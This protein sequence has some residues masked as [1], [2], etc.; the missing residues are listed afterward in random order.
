VKVCGAFLGIFFLASLLE[1]NVLSISLMGIGVM[2]VGAIVIL[3]GLRGEGIASLL[4][5][6]SFTRR[7]VGMVAAARDACRQLGLKVVAV[8]C[9]VYPNLLGREGH[10]MVAHRSSAGN[11]SS[12]S[13]A[14]SNFGP[15]TAA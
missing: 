12:E 3:Y 13:T 15:L 4:G 7:F 14:R 11:S 6:V 2:L 9:P 1:E 5:K 8:G 10:G